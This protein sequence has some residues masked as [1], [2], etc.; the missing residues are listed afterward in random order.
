[1]EAKRKT[2]AQRREPCFLEEGAR[3]GN[4]GVGGS[5][6]ACAPGGGQGDLAQPLAAEV[7]LGLVSG[8]EDADDG[9]PGEAEHE[10]PEDGPEHGGGQEE[11]PGQVVQE[12]GC[13]G[14]DL[15]QLVDVY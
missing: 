14:L 9:G 10:C 7:F 1:M 11:G 4:G 6:A 8:E 13:H 15:P 3:H 12:R 2:R 5:E